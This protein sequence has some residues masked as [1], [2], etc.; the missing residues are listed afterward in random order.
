MHPGFVVSAPPFTRA[1]QQQHHHNRYVCRATSVRCC[2]SAK[3]KEEPILRMENIEYRV[4][5][6][7]D[8]VVFDSVNFTVH[9]G[10]LVLVTGHNG[11]G[12]STLLQLMN[13][14]LEPDKGCTYWKEEKLKKP[15]HM[16]Q[17]VGV[18]MQSPAKYFFTRTVLQELIVG[19]ADITPDDVRRVMKDVGLFNISLRR[20]PHNLSGGEMR[21]LALASQ[22][23][24]KPTPQLFTLDEPLVGVDWFGRNDIIQLLGELKPKFAM[25]IVSHEPSHLLHLADRVVQVAHGKIYETPRTVIDKALQIL[26]DNAKE[27]EAVADRMREIL[28]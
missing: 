15:I 9:A 2:A 12:K 23:I 4:P 19:R 1:S 7:Y 3:T 13:G 18:V 26:D 27:R 6:D 20:H 28:G 10:E 11:S 5:M 14:L 22:M 17:N 24:R 16:I 25:V 21:R 8:R